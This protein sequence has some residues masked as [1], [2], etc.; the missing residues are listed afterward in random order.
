MS[1]QAD[2]ELESKALPKPDLA[3]TRACLPSVSA[4]GGAVLTPTVPI[5]SSTPVC[6]AAP[7]AIG[8]VCPWTLSSPRALHSYCQEYH[9]S[10]QQLA[11]P[12]EWSLVT[13]L[14]TPAPF[15]ASSRD[16]LNLFICGGFFKKTSLFRNTNTFS[17]HKIVSV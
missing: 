3:T 2:S 16:A 15:T 6:P 14:C 7:S 4:S 12:R 1:R 9:L 8:I 5:P 13:F 17:S 10:L 11:A